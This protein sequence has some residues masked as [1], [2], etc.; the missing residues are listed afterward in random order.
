[1]LALVKS[2]QDVCADA[3]AVAVSE[4]MPKALRTPNMYG[5]NDGERYNSRFNP[6]TNGNS[7]H[8]P[9]R[10]AT[11][12]QTVFGRS[13]GQSELRCDNLSRADSGDLRRGG[14]STL[15]GEAIRESPLHLGRVRL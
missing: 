9:S 14:K 8:Y 4:A 5:N 11:T 15:N 2:E 13:L 7:P 3:H 6:D 1:L 12:V 10:L